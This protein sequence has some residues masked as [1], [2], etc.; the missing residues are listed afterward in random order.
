MLFNENSFSGSMKEGM[1]YRVFKVVSDEQKIKL[2]AF[3]PMPVPQKIQ[4][5]IHADQVQDFIA[6]FGESIVDDDV[7]DVERMQVSLYFHLI[8]VYV[9]SDMSLCENCY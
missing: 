6:S 9:I 4:C 1:S 7:L 3:P 8:C 2:G 5:N